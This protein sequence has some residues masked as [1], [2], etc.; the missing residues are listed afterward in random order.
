MMTQ[1]KLEDLAHNNFFQTTLIFASRAEG[2]HKR[3][4]NKTIPNVIFPNVKIPNQT[5]NQHNNPVNPS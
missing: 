1:S 5:I 2:R 4:L 3:F